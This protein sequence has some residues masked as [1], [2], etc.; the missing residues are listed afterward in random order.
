MIDLNKN[1]ILETV[2]MIDSQ[3]LDVRTVT[4]ALSLFDCVGD[5]ADEVAERVYRKIV[6][7]A[8]NL[9]KT[10]DALSEKYGVPIVNKRVSVTPISLVG[11]RCG[12]YETLAKALDRAAKEIG[13]D[14]IG[15]YTALVHKGMTDYER[16]FID[17]IPQALATTDKVCGSVNVGSTKSGIN[18]DAVRLLG[19]T[20]KTLAEKTKKSGG[21][22]CAKF[23]VFCNAV[24]DNPFMAGAYTG[25]GEGDAVINVGVS[26][27]GTVYAAL[28]R[29]G[30]D[31]DLMAVAEE[32]KRTAFKITRVGRL[33]AQS[34]AK[35]LNA[36]CGIV[37]LSLAPTPKVGDSVA[38]ILEEMG[39]ECTGAPGTTACLAIL[40]DAVKKGGVMA[41]SSVG[42]L[43]G[44]F[45]PV[46]EDTGMIEAVKKG[47]LSLEKLEAMTCVCSVGLDM[48]AVPGKTSA[49]TISAVIA[50]ECAIGMI[51]NKTTAVRIIPVPGKD[52]GDEVTFG[53][54][55]GRA[56]IMAVNAYGAEGF[57]RRG[58]RVPAPIHS[59]KN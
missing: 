44:A 55:L 3:N 34:A 15:G 46:S 11:A 27:P 35:E 57:I 16:A 37:D 29:L 9:A 49:E 22:G 26:G 30:K 8:G 14:Y 53:G 24:E 32:I 12:G 52:V 5:F 31:A 40:N 51:N 54:L 41:S 20:I 47:A 18:M 33:I 17:S 56:P 28:K 19:H 6:K 10:C 13:I 1:E 59:L 38:Q 2:R 21:A 45:I 36:E 50:D 25:V 23:V 43:S 7:N 48:I 39:L 4:M 58:G 42:G